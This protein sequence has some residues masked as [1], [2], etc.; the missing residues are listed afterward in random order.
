MNWKDDIKIKLEKTKNA[1]K[2]ITG[3]TTEEKN[4]F[5]E[6]LAQ[7]I[8]KESPNILKS[9]KKDVEKAQMAGYS[10]AF[11]DRLSLSE[12]NIEKIISSIENVRNLPDPVGKI[13]W[14][15]KRPNG[16]IIKRKRV[17][18]GVIG[19]IYESRP[20]V[21]VESSILCIKAGN[22]V[23]LKGGK[24]AKNSNKKLVE[25]IKKSLK[26]ASLPEDCV[27]LIYKGGRKSVKH[28][29]KFHQYIDLIIPRGGEELIKTVVENSSIPVIK[30]YKGI[31]HTYIDKY[32]NIDMAL[33]VTFN[34][35]VQ[36][37]GTC[38]AT[39]TLLVHKDIAKE[40]LP[41]MAKMFE[42]A[43]VEMRG[44]EE[45][46]KILPF[47]KKASED[48]WKIEYLDKIISIKVVNSI[49]EAIEHIGKYGT[50]HSDAIITENKEM[51]EKFLNMVDSAAVY[52]NASTRFTDGGEFG[53]GAEIGISTDKIHARGPMGLEELTIYK[54]I[55]YG[56]GQIRE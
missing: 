22:C 2:S 5:L 11:I 38:N 25:I 23:I 17:P 50:S 43:G 14:E 8:K 53:L 20:D 54:Y 45:T 6:N 29:L 49:E 3:L 31:C 28:L 41:E 7:N 32:T 40:F 56:N 39:E 42:E 10:N 4:K 47:I 15:N 36:R 27:N 9:N 1:Y 52:H 55:V 30:H 46:R 24:E 26:E 19:I 18:I 12:N 35:K 34:A 37:P 13:I 48:D 33:K 21:T 44:C 16:L 51:A